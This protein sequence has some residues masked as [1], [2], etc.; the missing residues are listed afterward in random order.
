M[1]YPL[2]SEYVEAIKSA[3]D[4]FE[5]LS[6]LRPVLVDDGLPVMTSGNFAVVFKMRD[7]RDGKLYAVKCFTK[8]QEGRSESYK[9]IA[10][11]LEYV[12]SNY[13]TPIRY[14]EQELFVDTEQTDETEFP[15]LLMD[16]VEGKTLDVYIK[17]NIDNQ[18]ALEM[19]SFLFSKMAAWLIT[20]P[21]AHG[22]LKP[23]NIILKEDGQL[24]LVD[25]DGMYFPAMKGQKAREVGSI[26]FR[27]PQ[28]TEEK[29]DEHVDDFPIASIALA[30]KA[31]ALKPIL[32]NEYGSDDRLL[33]SENDFLYLSQSKL[34]ASFQQLMKDKEFC[35]LYGIFMIA[36]ALNDISSISYRLFSL[37]KSHKEDIKKVAALYLKACKYV[38]EKEYENAYKIFR[39]LA[40]RKWAK[41][42]KTEWT[43]NLCGCVLGENGLGYMYAKGLYVEQ[44]YKK[45]VTWFKKASDKG[46]SMA[47]FNLSVAYRKGEG[48]KADIAEWQRLIL[49]AEEQGYGP[50]VDILTYDF[51]ENVPNKLLD[52]MHKE[53][54]E[55][56]SVY[57]I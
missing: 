22:D 51:Q 23:D 45:A 35:T 14:L 40:K 50:A 44:D 55:K 26:G 29:F 9:L 54:T 19:L 20:Q 16:W 46:F 34:I 11:E 12:S 31:I 56:L 1:N 21:F 28:R 2:I 15:V 49:L 3:E 4:N 43:K 41:G 27:H 38:E 17:E 25:Y 10:D 33:F 5:E 48:V 39:L 52:A 36:W 32:W 30:L 37:Q 24:V 47:Q 53:K 7:E 42:I 8:E 6:Y 18:F 57:R 13:L